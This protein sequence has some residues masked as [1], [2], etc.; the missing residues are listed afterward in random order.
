MIIGAKV[1]DY[2]A[3]NYYDRLINYQTR[4]VEVKND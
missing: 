2:P 3:D 4:I 1:S